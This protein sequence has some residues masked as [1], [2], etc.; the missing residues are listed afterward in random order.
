LDETPALL[1]VSRS[2]GGRTWRLRSSDDR[3]AHAIA[4]VLDQP[5]I[6][7]RVLAARGV[8][9]DNVESFMNPR[10]R[11]LLPDPLS[12]QDMGAAAARIA[13]AIMGDEKVAVFGDYDVDGATS[14]AL[15]TRYFR[16]L[17]RNLTVYIP[18]RRREGYGPNSAALEKLAAAGCR[19]VMTVD[20]GIVAFD[21]LAAGRAAGLDIIVLDHHQ[22]EPRL[23]PAC[24]VVNPN[25]LDD[26][27]GLGQLAAVGVVFIL[28]VAVNRALRERGWFA[29]R[30][31]PNLMQWL[32][33]VAL[34]T[35][36]DVV[37]LTGLNRALTVQGIKVLARRG[38]IGLRAI[39]E[40]ANLDTRPG[41]YHLGYVFG[42]RINAGG[43]VGR[44]ELG[45]RLL[46]TD[47]PAEA[48]HLAHELDGYNKKRRE[49]ENNI[50]EEASARA[51]TA[52]Q[53][54][55]P[56]IFLAS[57]DWHEG[58]VGIIAGRLK[59]RF[60]RPAIVFAV[61]EG[62]AKGSG[63][64]VTNVDLGA[65]VT[66]AKQSDLLIN[67]GGHAMA[68][69]LTVAEE[70]L[71]EVR[72]FLNARLG[73]EITERFEGPELIVDA[74]LAVGGVTRKLYDAL[75]DAGPYGAGHSE[76]RFVIT[77][78]DIVKADVVGADHVRVL[79]AGDGNARLKAIAFRSAGTAL[80]QAIMNARGERLHLAGHLR[81]DD[82]MGKR[83]VQLVLEDAAPAI[84]GGSG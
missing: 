23:P 20:C 18:D 80:G 56:L 69:G 4:Q 52:L 35:V 62:I 44:S 79:V 48:D 9:P 3:N 36:C 14:S 55:P 27:S 15:L 59:D 60:H 25:R 72:E 39:G 21:A 76:P 73:T 16:A 61:R 31:E 66:A 38:N 7:G 65:A 82:W 29:E 43:R 30:E 28:L 74:I 37:P 22:A 45:A 33:L 63:R 64:S 40:V 2:H 77:A 54:D 75:E 67:G 24:A 12:L 42:P 10:L 83:G 1:G 58:V 17:G 34:G 47:D 19:L 81:A 71:E 57:E 11:D 78:A 50:F 68:A 26:D 5:E 41:T 84:S 49:I 8:A 13:D 51:E 32:D 46:S 6:V 53:D 70:R